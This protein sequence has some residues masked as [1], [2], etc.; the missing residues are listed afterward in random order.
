MTRDPYGYRDHQ[1]KIEKQLKARPK[2]GFIKPGKKGS[3][4]GYN[5]MRYDNYG[6]IEKRLIYCSHCGKNKRTSIKQDI[7]PV[8][9]G[10][11]L[12]SVCYKCGLVHKAKNTGWYPLEH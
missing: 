5:V 6:Y 2:E 12:W 1:I 8:I 11:L 3:I 10:N 9:K 7:E 4:V